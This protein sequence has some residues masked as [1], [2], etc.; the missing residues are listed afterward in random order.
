VSPNSTPRLSRGVLR[1]R[2][3]G[4]IATNAGVQW[5]KARWRHTRAACRARMPASHGSSLRPP[6]N[7]PAPSIAATKVAC[8]RSSGLGRIAHEVHTERRETRRGAAEDL[9]QDRELAARAVALEEGLERVH[10]TYLVEK[11]VP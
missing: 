10:M 8:T 9:G 7:E 1:S 11:L 3:P 4:S 2:P 6:W 5:N